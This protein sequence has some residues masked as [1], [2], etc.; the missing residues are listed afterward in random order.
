MSCPSCYEIS[1]DVHVGFYRTPT[2]D[3]ATHPAQELVRKEGGNVSNQVSAGIPV[4]AVCSW[5]H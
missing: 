4:G 3:I 5:R 2:I 1:C